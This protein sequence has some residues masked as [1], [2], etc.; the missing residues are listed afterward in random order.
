MAVQRLYFRSFA[1]GEV[2]GELWGRIDDVKYATG[3]AATS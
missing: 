1:G 2:S 3:L